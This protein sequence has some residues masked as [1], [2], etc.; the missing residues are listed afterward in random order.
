MNSFTYMIHPSAFIFADRV[1][2]YDL[3]LYSEASIGIY[4]E[5]ADGD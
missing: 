2:Y 3:C 4:L 5:S 1:T